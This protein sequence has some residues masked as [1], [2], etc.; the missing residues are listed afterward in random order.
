M[1]RR[2]HFTGATREGNSERAKTR[3]LDCSNLDM[4]RGKRE[5]GD[6]TIAVSRKHL[7]ARIGPLPMFATQQAYLRIS[8]VHGISAARFVALARVYN[9]IYRL[10]V[11][12]VLHAS[13]EKLSHGLDK[14]VG[15]TIRDGENYIREVVLSFS[16]SYIL[17]YCAERN[18]I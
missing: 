18:T 10:C 17:P 9:E 1:S 13:R 14:A 11:D 7:C 8:G 16:R 6:A 5:E 2:F 12:F 3:T 15:K 4:R